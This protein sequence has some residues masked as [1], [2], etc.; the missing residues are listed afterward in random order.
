[1]IASGSTFLTHP[2]RVTGICSVCCQ[3]HTL[4]SSFNRSSTAAPVSVQALPV[5]CHYSAGTHVGRGSL[6]TDNRVFHI[7]S[8]TWDE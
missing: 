7:M 2:G 6:E 8:H 4:A 3:R 1:M 5:Q